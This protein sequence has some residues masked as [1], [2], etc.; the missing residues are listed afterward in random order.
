MKVRGTQII[1]QNVDVEVSTREIFSTL[2]HLLLQKWNAPGE[3]INKGGKWEEWT[4][5]GHG[6]GLTDIHRDA[7]QE[8]KDGMKAID[9][10]RE[11]F[12]ND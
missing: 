6:S 3:Y 1:R 9:T 12:K 5:T 11:L 8:E 4:D 7:T 2:K 10:L